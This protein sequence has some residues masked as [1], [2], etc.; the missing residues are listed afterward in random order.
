MARRALKDDIPAP[1]WPD[2]KTFMEYLLDSVRD[3]FIDSM[4]H[5]VVKALLGAE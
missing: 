4:E 3:R 1:D 5:P 2:Q